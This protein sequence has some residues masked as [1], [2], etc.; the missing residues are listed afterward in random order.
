MVKTGLDILLD[1]HLPELRGVRV[2]V[3]ANHTSVTGELVHIVDALHYAGVKICALLGPEHGVRG[4]VVDGEAISDSIDERLNV[5]VYS[6]YGKS[7]S[8]TRESFAGIDLMIVDLQDVGARFYTFI[9]TMANV[10]SACGECGV[11]VWILD[12]PNP[13]SGL[14]PDGPILQPEF[15]SFAGM[16]PIPIRHG[17]TIGE[18]AGLFVARFGVDCD[19]RII[20]MQG[21]VR[22]MWH[23]V[24]GLLWVAPSPNMP[25]LDT[26]TVYPGMCLLEGTNVS[27]GRGT[28]RPFEIFGAPW[29]N[30]PD[31]RDALQ[32]YNL[33]GV[34]LREAYF[35]PWA[36]KFNGNHCAGLQIHITDRQ[37]F[38]PVIT[39][40]AVLS[41]INHL[42]PDHFD[43]REPGENGKRYFDL[44][45][46]S[47]SLRE[48]IEAG[49]SPWDITQTWREG[50]SEY[51]DQ[52]NS[53]LLYD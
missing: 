44:L 6:L 3:L 18:L 36:S 2:G 8:P 25:T 43:F 41:A 1:E 48:F 24:T 23:D 16:Y 49:H 27:E 12:R 21:W 46:G 34:A 51:W 5:P 13:I 17:L 4:D 20:R 38:R 40:V 19:L 14:T 28:T 9:Y 45:A 26:A 22:E 32:A 47:A 29:I 53:L 39:G 30:P 35:T 52:V 7:K 50:I 31:L 11:P 42:Y 15:S 33:P 37:A 10:M